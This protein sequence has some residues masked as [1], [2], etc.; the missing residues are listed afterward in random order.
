MGWNYLS[1]PKLQ[2]CN[3]WSL[4]MDKWF[5]PTL[6]QTGDYLS[7][8][9]LKLKRVSKRGHWR[10]GVTLPGLVNSWSCGNM[11]WNSRIALKTQYYQDACQVSNLWTT[12]NRISS[13]YTPRWITWS[14]SY[15]V[16]N[17]GVINW[18][19]TC[20]LATNVRCSVRLYQ[21]S[22]NTRLGC[23]LQCSVRFYMF[24]KWQ[25]CEFSNT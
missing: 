16:F 14:R 8:L 12:H 17:W 20:D 24:W 23:K 22:F 2:R 3:R 6:Y 18:A 10:Q 19:I 13:S 7:M 9:G 25:G 5:H 21:L 11:C 1:I 15:F 4:E